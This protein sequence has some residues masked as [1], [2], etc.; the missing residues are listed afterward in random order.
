MV[1]IVCLALTA[2]GQRPSSTFVLA[3]G[4]AVDGPA[5]DQLEQL[6][7]AYEQIADAVLPAVVNIQTTQVIQASQSPFF[8][9]PMWRQFFGNNPGFTVPQEQREHDLGTGVIVSP[10]GYI[11]TNDPVVFWGK[12]KD[13]EVMLSDQRTFKARIV[14]SDRSKIGRASCRE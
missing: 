4:P 13:I 12:A 2:F 14:G 9:K 1:G 11:V 5:I 8:S 7:K 6:N 3:S 10:D